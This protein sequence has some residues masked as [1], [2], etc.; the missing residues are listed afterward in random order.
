LTEK[1]PPPVW[2]SEPTKNPREVPSDYAEQF[3]ERISQKAEKKS[4]FSELWRK[5]AV[6]GK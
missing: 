1:I 4:G 3:L 2:F 6:L 5:S